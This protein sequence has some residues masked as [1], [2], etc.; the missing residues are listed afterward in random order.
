MTPAVGRDRGSAAIEAPI[1]VMALLAVLFFVVGALR[2]TSAS[3]DVNAAARSAARAAA[4]E[5]SAPAATAAASSVASTMLDD[6]GVACVGGP[7]V[8]I[9]RDPTP[10]SAITVTITCVVSLADVVLA[11]FPGTRTVTGTGVEFVDGIRGGT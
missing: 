7:A 5:R 9:D 8:G 6:R 3:G 4:A 10:G 11:G 2:I 1:A